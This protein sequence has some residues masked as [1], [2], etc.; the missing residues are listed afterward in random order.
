VAITWQLG[1]V[2]GIIVSRAVLRLRYDGPALASH[3]MDVRE[4]GGALIALGDLFHEANKT[5]NGDATTVRVVIRPD[6]EAKCVDFSIEIIQTILEAAKGLFSGEQPVTAAEIIDWILRVAGLG[7]LTA[8]GYGLIQYIKHRRGRSIKGTTE[9]QDEHGNTL[10]R[11]EYTDDT[12]P[13][14]LAKPVYRMAQNKK[15]MGA[16]ERVTDPLREEA[17]ITELEMYTPET[18]SDDRQKIEKMHTPFFL[19]GSVIEVPDEPE[20]ED[21]DTILRTIRVYSPV[22]DPKAS[23]WRFEMDGKH[24]YIDISSTTIAVDAIARGGAF[25]GDG[26]RVKLKVAHH[27]TQK[28]RV[29]YDYKVAQVLDF[30]PAPRQLGMEVNRPEERS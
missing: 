1:V 27:T 24:E 25:V 22:Y 13:D 23:M 3:E 29:G 28:G 7:G 4:F 19:A 18:K 17:G 6:I 15:I 2:R 30:F 11:I 8:S 16:L 10:Y 12:E 14:V 20:A 21:V 9:F 5:L 26:Y